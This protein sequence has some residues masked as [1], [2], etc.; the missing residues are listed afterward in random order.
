MLG[1]IYRIIPL[2]TLMAVCIW[3][4]T[5]A[6]APECECNC[7]GIPYCDVC[8][9]LSEF[10]LTYTPTM[11]NYLSHHLS[12]KLPCSLVVPPPLFSLP[13]FSECNNF[14]TQYLFLQL[15]IFSNL[16][17]FINA[18]YIIMFVQ[19]VL[20]SFLKKSLPVLIFFYRY[21]LESNFHSNIIYPLIFVSY[22][23]PH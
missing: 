6:L 3:E 23:P 19:V 17:F 21:W 9:I 14:D 11:V 13:L 18:F 1:T 16:T 7:L 4:Y 12:I 8:F 20:V 15:L 10:L 22:V 5:P 2:V